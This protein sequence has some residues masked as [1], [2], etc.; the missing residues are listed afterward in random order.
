MKDDAG[1]NGDVVAA[2]YFLGERITGWSTWSMTTDYVEQDIVGALGDITEDGVIELRVKV[3]GTAG[4][5][6]ADDFSYS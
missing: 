3:R 6:F 5:V 2:L 4:N 1:F